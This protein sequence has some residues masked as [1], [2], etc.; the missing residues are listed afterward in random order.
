[1][2]LWR[3]LASTK[4]LIENQTIL[5]S[6]AGGKLAIIEQPG[7]KRL[8]VEG[9][10][11]TQAEARK[12]CRE[13]GGHI[14]KLPRDWLARFARKQRSKPLKIGR[15][16]LITR[17]SSGFK[18]AGAIPKSPFLAIPAATAF[19]TGEH[20]TTA[21][22]LRLLEQITRRMK[23]GWSLVDLGTGSGIIALAARRFGAKR[24]LA[25]DVDP[26]AIATAKANARLNR[27]K[28]VDFRLADVRKWRF[29]AK[30]DVATANLFSEL[31]V[32]ILPRVR[33]SSRLILS[34]VMRKQ[35]NELRRALRANRMEIVQTR[36]Q[37][38]WIALLAQNRI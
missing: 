30:I 20:A 25:I 35:E 6:R 29:P 2:Y 26:T 18:T 23:P 11:K 14:N 15:R 27:I 3:R 33:H 21:M 22:S 7:R 12:L 36:R 8:Q 10:C 38:K 16:L 4:W 13:F 37:G 1:M 9:G 34:G 32:E 31:L 5:E 17:S 24:V 28:N 19:G